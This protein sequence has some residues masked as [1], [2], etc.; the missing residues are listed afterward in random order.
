MLTLLH[1]TSLDSVDLLEEANPR[2]ASMEYAPPLTGCP[3]VLCGG[4]GFGDKGESS[5]L[6]PWLP[7]ILL[8]LLS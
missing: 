5:V 3:D 8:A 2:I 7:S 1:A 4:W 6:S